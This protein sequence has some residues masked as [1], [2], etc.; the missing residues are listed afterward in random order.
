MQ[1]MNAPVKCVKT[2]G[3]NLILLVFLNSKK[4]IFKLHMVF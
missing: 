4:Y 1:H 3:M 2:N